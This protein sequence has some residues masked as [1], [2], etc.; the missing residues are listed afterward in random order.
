[1]NIDALRTSF[2]DLGGVG[3]AAVGLL[4]GAL[5]F[6]LLVLQPLEAR[7]AELTEQVASRGSSAAAG[8]SLAQTAEKLA[9]LHAFLETREEPTQLLAKLYGAGA[10]AGV[11]LRAAEYRLHK[12]GTRIE[13]YEITLP[14]TGSYAQVRS[15]IG[16]AMKEIPALSLDQV[17]FR[18]QRADDTQVQAEMRLTLHLVRP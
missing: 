15:F 8:S 1:M 10:A 7:K 6:L 14:V 13:R 3:L 2:R 16:G 11:E 18:R 17:S 5:L 4:A 9:A 12:T